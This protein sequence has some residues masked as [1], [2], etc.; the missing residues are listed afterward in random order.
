[1]LLIGCSNNPSLELISSTVEIR[2]D[3]SGG[4][5]ITSGEQKG[6]FI[7]PLSLSYHFVLK[8]TGTK[9]L[10]G[11]EKI[12]DEQFE[13]D[14]GIKVYIEPNEK[15][16]AVSEEVLGFII[17]DGEE[18]LGMGKTSIPVLEPNQEGE[19][20]LDFNLGALE[21]NPKIK[22]APSTEKLDKLKRD[23]MDATLIVSI[24]D[25]EI[26]RFDLSNSN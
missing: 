10:G 12:N 21:E 17:Y 25:E 24:E 14:D 20:T 2:D 8:N 1:M 5:G 26:A 4:I 15:L 3:K 9:T 11:M 6:E 16:K 23:A 7:Q 22:L 18:N 13:F 19:Y